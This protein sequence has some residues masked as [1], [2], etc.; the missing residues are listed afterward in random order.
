[1]VDC[2]SLS[3]QQDSRIRNPLHKARM[4]RVCQGETLQRFFSQTCW[5]QVPGPPTASRVVFDPD[6]RNAET[7]AP[8]SAASQ[9]STEPARPE[10][11]PTPDNNRSACRKYRPCPNA[12]PLRTATTSNPRRHAP[13]LLTSGG[14][15]VS[16]FASA[17][18][19]LRTKEIRLP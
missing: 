6:G 11:V 17:N 15:R 14:I 5:E 4:P 10:S 19:S 7:A 12:L 8:Q 9:R 2:S 1:M 16:W 13:P 3:L 18:R